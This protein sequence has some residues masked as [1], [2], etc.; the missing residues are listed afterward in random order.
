VAEPT[1]WRPTHAHLRAVGLAAACVIIAVLSRRAD[2]A[3][4][5]VPFIGAAA[6]G[7]QHRPHLAPRA[8][9]GLAEATVFEGQVTA[10]TVAIGTDGG[11]TGDVV[12]VCLRAGP[13]VG[14]RPVSGA[15]AMPADGGPLVVPVATRAARWGRHSIALPAA[16]CTSILGAFRTD[17]LADGP[18]LLTTL[19]L[20][21]EFDAGD[22]V[23]RPAGLVGLHR[24]HRQG[25]GSEPAEIRPFRTGDR[26]RRINWRV[27]SR[28]GELHV[29]STWSDRDTHVLLL[30]DTEADIGRSEGVDGRASSLDIAVRAAAAIAEHFLRAG[31]R[32]GLVDLG[33]RVRDVPVGSGRQHL[34]RLLDALVVAEP[35]GDHRAEPVQLRPTVA[36]SLIVVLSPLVGRTGQTQ[37]AHLAQHGHTL[38]VVDTLPPT[39]D[40]PV[41]PWPALAARVRAMERQA[42][43]DHLG[44]MGIPVVPW[45]GAGT[46]DEVLRDVSRLAMAPRGRR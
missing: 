19:P 37:I 35:G 23:P 32:V 7:A 11:A 46:L 31:D 39:V 21:A 6:W 33:R 30:L 12:A 45:R 34:R 2:I 25:G 10:T 9:L 4:L 26:L 24:A 28:T 14:W 29:T 42:E 18:V 1:R 41:A 27:S 3:I 20:S 17:G 38:V 16:A 22:A 44:E 40:P 13:A 5:G 43:I 8:E 36:G 15:C